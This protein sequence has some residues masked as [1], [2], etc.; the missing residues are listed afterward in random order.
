MGMKERLIRVRMA[1]RREQY[2]VARNYIEAH[3]WEAPEETLRKAQK[4]ISP[5]A[6]LLLEWM[7]R[8]P[9]TY[10]VEEDRQPKADA[11]SRDPCGR[12]R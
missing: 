1:V 12:G 11:D 7:L 6:L 8:T 9:L 2:Q 10:D 5:A 3:E 4:A